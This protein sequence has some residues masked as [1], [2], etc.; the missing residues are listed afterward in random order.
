[1][2][3]PSGGFEVGVGVE[4]RYGGWGQ[5]SG[6]GARR[7]WRPG[8]WEDRCGGRNS[9]ATHSPWAAEMGDHLV[10]HGDGVKDV[11]FEVQDCDSIVQVRDRA[12]AGVGTEP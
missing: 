3:R 6:R 9:N 2:R 8:D 5:G 4:T 10:R 11:A 1:M 7:R 12:W